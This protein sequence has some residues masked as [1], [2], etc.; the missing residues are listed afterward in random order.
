M[1]DLNKLIKEH[2]KEFGGSLKS[3]LYLISEEEIYLKLTNRKGRRVV[4][5]DSIKEGVSDGRKLIYK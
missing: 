3:K 1:K 5:V 4:V 2:D